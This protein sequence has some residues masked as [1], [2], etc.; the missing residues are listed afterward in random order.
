MYIYWRQRKRCKN[1]GNACG[2]TSGNI[3]V[4]SQGRVC[5]GGSF[6][7]ISLGSFWRER[8]RSKK[9]CNACGNTLGISLIWR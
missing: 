7:N 4:E 3:V 2:T 8:K 6:E 9:R 1:R 5:F